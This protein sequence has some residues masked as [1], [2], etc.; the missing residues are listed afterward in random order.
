M[1]NRESVTAKAL[2]LLP[3][4][5][6]FRRTYAFLRRSQWW[7]REEL[8]AYQRAEL[9]RLLDHAYEHVPYYRRIF[10]ERGLKPED[11]RNLADLRLLPFLTKEIIQ[12]NLAELRA[13]N[14]PE[15]AFE[16]VTTGG[17]TG[18]PVGFYY[19]KGVSRAREWA[20]MKAQWDRVGYRFRDRCVI[21]RGHVVDPDPEG[22]FWKKAL[23]GRWLIM[24]SYHITEETLP[25]YIDRIRSFRPKYIQAY[26]SIISI[27]ATYMQ[28]HEVEPF[29]TLKA[30]LCGSENLY[31]WQRELVE[32]V[33]GCRIYS[34]Y[35]NSEQT[36]LAGECE[37]SSS[38]HIF[39]EY[40][41]VELIGKDNLPVTAPGELGEVVATNLT[42]YVCPL[43]RYRTMDLA[44]RDTDHCPCGRAYPLLK[45][46]EGRLQEFIVTRNDRL[47]PMTAV[48]M[49][50]A[51]FDN[52]IQFQ[53]YQEQEGE[54]ILR[55]VRKPGYTDRD[56]ESI[57]QESQKKLGE[58]VHITIRFVDSIPRTERGKYRFLIQQLPLENC[59]L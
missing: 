50:S 44:V 48:N 34:W 49:H 59:D 41:I 1:Y 29:P 58:D 19:E 54:V 45:K 4:Y 42:N 31:P 13:T 21:L 20:F 26:P 33:F 52:V 16:Y 28:K 56:T 47:I 15:N 43:I 23:F 39:P 32:D 46:V 35:G 10:D 57:R 18:I 24:S 55:I 22:V 40:G 53:F 9:A 2:S 14:Y 11:I 5:S 51:V 6:T 8:E 37:E 17:S 27:L 3:T 7:S 38:Y 30:I 36:V 25:A 12:N